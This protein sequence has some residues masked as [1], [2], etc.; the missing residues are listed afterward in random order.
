MLTQLRRGAS[1]WLAKLLIALL[2]LSFAIWGIADIFRGFG[3][4]QLA[5]VG[6]T[7][8]TATDF[9]RDYNRAVQRLSQQAGRPIPADE[10]IQFGLPQRV[11]SQLA[12]DALLTDAT[13]D[14]GIDVGDERVAQAIRSDETF[15]GPDGSFNRS[16]FQQILAA[17][18]LDEDGYIED[19]RELMDRRQLVDGLFG[20]LDV[21]TAYLAALNQY[22]NE[23]RTI[24]FFLVGRDSIAAIAD[25]TEEELSTFYDENKGR[26]AAPEYRA[27]NI[28]QVNADTL[29]DPASVSEDDVRQAY[30]SGEFGTPERRHVQQV[31]F[32]DRA[33]AE[34]A[35]DT[36]SSGGTFQEVLT[37]AGRTMNDVD[38]G[39]V[40][41]SDIVDPAVADAAFSMEEPGTEIVDGR[42]GTVLV[43]VSEIQQ[44]DRQPLEEVAG[45]IRDRLAR[46]AAQDE[47]VDLYDEVED[48]FA[49]GATIAEVADRFGLSLRNVPAVSAAGAAPDG[50]TVQL[51][52]KQELLSDAFDTEVGADNPPIQ[53][54]STDYV[55]YR[56]SDVTPARDREL[57]EVRGQVFAAW[58]EDQVATRI[59]EAADEAA[60]RIRNGESIDAVADSLGAT[61]QTSEPFTRQGSINGLP[62]AAVSEAFSG[63]QDTVA[64][65]TASQGQQAV[66]QVASV[67][68]P[69]FFAEAADNVPAR[70]RLEQSLGDALV[71]AYVSALEQERPVQVNQQMLNQIVGVPGSGAG[72]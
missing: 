30:E 8:I 36:L 45:S 46:Q 24:R 37:A 43:R 70:Q 7:E 54:S 62:S 11:L 15:Q 31:V 1:T 5:R 72:S 57:D 2:V 59:A 29:A 25:P 50:S 22:S 19:Q 64:T 23:E 58:T 38:L 65:T 39:V 71:G 9:Q 56:V 32:G 27:L 18:G 66:L 16:R 67:N 55:W 41:R 68:R 6:N 21:P 49:G 42:F 40:S 48:A 33:E 52:A 3:A 17:N 61:L 35:A 26:F 34:D 10:A 14:Y 13:K 28:L 20:G 4:N 44:A 12:T 60:E 69:A 53:V 47:V 51:P 63:P